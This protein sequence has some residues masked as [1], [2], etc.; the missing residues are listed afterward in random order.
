LRQT[1][2]AWDRGTL[3]DA[4]NVPDATADARKHRISEGDESYTAQNLRTDG[5]PPNQRHG[6]VNIV[7]LAARACDTQAAD[8][9]LRPRERQAER[10]AGANK[11]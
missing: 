7:D 10:H 4:H 9:F 5:E 6:C 1:S 3:T 8:G 11:Q 2:P